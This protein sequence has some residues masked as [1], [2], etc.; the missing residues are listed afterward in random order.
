MKEQFKT[1]DKENIRNLHFPKTDVL[2][3]DIQRKLRNLELQKALTLGNSDKVKFNI[4]FEDESNKLKVY[5]TIWGL[6]DDQVILKTG[7]TLPVRRIYYLE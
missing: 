4:Y 3:D 1:I 5:T 2:S 6:T 7:V